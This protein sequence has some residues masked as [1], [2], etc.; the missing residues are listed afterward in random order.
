MKFVEYPDRDFLMMKAADQI[1]SELRSALGHEERVTFVVPGGT[2]PGPIF[3]TL[4]GVDLDW[5]RVDILLTDE[6]WVP[7]DSDRSNAR[8]VRSRLLKDRAA[9]ATF[10]TFWRD[11]PGPEA[12]L[13]ELTA[14]LAPLL[15]PNVLLI[16]MGDDMHC[17]SIFPD[18]DQRDAAL[19]TDAPPVLAMRRPGEEGARVTLTMPVLT[20]SMSIHL[21]ITGEDKRLALRQA[22]DLPQKDAPVAAILANATVHWAA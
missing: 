8:L 22:Q 6:R 9:A 18:G 13:D 14:M 21:L 5:A 12:A 2:T 7:E 19:A 4:A 1:A 20:E 15:P 17:A 11:T 3:E 10:H 16:G